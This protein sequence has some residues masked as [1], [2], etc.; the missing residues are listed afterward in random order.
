MPPRD[1]QDYEQRRQQIIDGALE[2]F[3]QKGFNGASNKDIAEAAR[4]GSPGLI[5]HYF[6]DK[7]DLLHQVIVERVP[8]LQVIE[9]AQQLMLLP[10]P[11][12]LPQMAERVMRLY[13][14]PSAMA[15]VRVAL[16]ESLRNPAV[17]RMVN[18]AGPGRGLRLL[19]DYMQRQ[20]D[21]GQLRRI[22]PEIAARAFVGP[23]LAYTLTRRVFEQPEVLA[24]T[25]EEMARQATAIFLRGMAP[26]GRPTGASEVA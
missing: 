3:A 13:S 22:D 8:V 26:E 23:L 5:Y 10:P 7:V 2:A 9:D 17:A 15:V 14:Q 11:E 18:E 20:M 25:P 4:I 6:K 1:E 12:A 16:V 19:A 21:A 24:I